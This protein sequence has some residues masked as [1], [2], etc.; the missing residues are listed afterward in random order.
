[1]EISPLVRQEM[2]AEKAS[3][4]DL[5]AAGNAEGSIILFQPQDSEHISARTIND[6]ITAIAPAW[7]CKTYAVG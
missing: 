2:F 5:H 1:M 7:D 4:T 6:P 3:G